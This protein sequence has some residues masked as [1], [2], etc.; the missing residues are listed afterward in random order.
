[1]PMKRTLYK[2]GSWESF[3]RPTSIITENSTICNP[4]DE[5]L[6]EA[7]YEITEVEIVPDV[8]VPTYEDLVID[9][10]RKRYSLDQEFAIL[11]QRDTKVEEFN[12]YFN[13]CEQC[14]AQAKE[15]VNG[16]T[17]VNV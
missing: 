17:Q 12:E 10:I 3:K 7:G 15:E 8:Y 13:Y 5:H 16:Q 14:K 4:S 11:R 6:I 2:K 9:K 1:M